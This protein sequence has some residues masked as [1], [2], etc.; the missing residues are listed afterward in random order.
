M[1]VVEPIFIPAADLSSRHPCRFDEPFVEIAP[2]GSARKRPSRQFN[3]RK[4]ASIITVY[5]VR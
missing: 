3:I 5:D 1:A 4:S 2:V